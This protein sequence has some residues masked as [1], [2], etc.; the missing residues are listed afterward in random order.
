MEKIPNDIE[1]IVKEITET[2]NE[3][4]KEQ[5]QT[6]IINYGTEMEADKDLLEKW[7]IFDPLSND[8]GNTEAEKVGYLMQTA[9]FVLLTLQLYLLPLLYGLLGACVYVL[10]MLSNEIKGL[11]FTKD[12]SYK[13]A[14]RIATG[15]VAGMAVGWFFTSKTSSSLF[16]SLSPLALSFLAG[17]SVDVLFAAMDK[18]VSAFAS[19]KSKD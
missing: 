16:E 4:M 14:L 15:G 3:N 7:S 17:Y 5:L 8:K 13:Y 11:A 19:G 9:R 12:S 2:D 6:K 10:R 1:K 18:F